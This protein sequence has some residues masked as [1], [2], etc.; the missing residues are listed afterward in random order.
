MLIGKSM[1]CMSKFQYLRKKMPEGIFKIFV[2]DIH[3]YG[4]NIPISFVAFR[5]PQR[6]TLSCLRQFYIPHWHDI[7]EFICDILWPY[8]NLHIISATLQRICFFLNGCFHIVCHNPAPR[9]VDCGSI[10]VTQLYILRSS[11]GRF[12]SLHCHVCLLEG[13]Q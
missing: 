7:S 6:T 13:T 4:G 3:V 5:R 1:I 10:S 9:L 8:V 11:W 12:T 2:G